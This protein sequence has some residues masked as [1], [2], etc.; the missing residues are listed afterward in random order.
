M[1]EAVNV[2]CALGCGNPLNP[3]DEGTWKEVRG[4]VGGPRK[5]SMVLRE[6][7]G[8][9]AHNS[10][11]EKARRGQVA[12]QPDM[13]EQVMQAPAERCGICHRP[14]PHNAVEA[15]VCRAMMLV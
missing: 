3:Y 1:P 12:D 15:G 2:G 6:D 7:T 4:F 14:L 5:D 8:A 9:F 11:I 13:F 10:C